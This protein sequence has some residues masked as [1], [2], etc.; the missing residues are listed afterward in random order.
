[1]NHAGGGDDLGKSEIFCSYQNRNPDSSAR[2]ISSVLSSIII[3]ISYF[4]LPVLVLKV[5]TLHYEWFIIHEPQRRSGCS[6]QEHNILVIT[7][8]E[9]QTVLHVK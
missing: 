6:G 5:L 1:M 2:K 4:G 3:V 7:R 8:I 9:T